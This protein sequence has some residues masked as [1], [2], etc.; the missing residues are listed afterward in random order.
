MTN[1]NGEVE[2]EE[3][4]RSKRSN[5]GT[6]HAQI[7]GVVRSGKSAFLSEILQLK[8]STSPE[9]EETPDAEWILRQKQWA[10]SLHG[11]LVFKANEDGVKMALWQRD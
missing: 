1:E 11:R 3:G 6:G 10:D 4:M 5:R 7:V 2:P 9:V 8:R